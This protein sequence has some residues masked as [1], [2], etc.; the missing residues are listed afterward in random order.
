MK[1]AIK[2]VLQKILISPLIFEK[3]ALEVETVKINAASLS[4][5]F[6]VKNNNIA[7]KVAQVCKMF[8]KIFRLATEF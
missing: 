1:F 6:S 5:F 4:E 2:N 8:A 3:I 7:A